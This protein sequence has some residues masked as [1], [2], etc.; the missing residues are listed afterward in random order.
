MVFFLK[1]P[2]HLL[3]VTA[4]ANLYKT[5]PTKWNF[6]G[7][8][9]IK[10]LTFGEKAKKRNTDKLLILPQRIVEIVLLFMA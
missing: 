7:V 10:L 2:T 3:T 5:L 1:T 8:K 9:T 4:K 6:I